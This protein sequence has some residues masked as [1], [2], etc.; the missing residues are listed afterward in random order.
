MGDRDGSRVLR[1][2]PHALSLPSLEVGTARVWY[3]RMILPPADLDQARLSLIKELREG[4][5]VSPGV[6]CSG[7]N[8]R[9][10]INS[11]S[12]Q[13]GH[14]FSGSGCGDDELYCW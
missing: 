11:R 10:V 5:N 14:D 9:A 1:A 7:V 13:S 2:A 8:E 12:L 3:G 6:G 4:G